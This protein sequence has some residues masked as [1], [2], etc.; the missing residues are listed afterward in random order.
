MGVLDDLGRAIR[1]VEWDRE[2]AM[3]PRAADARGRQLGTL[4]ALH[5]RELVR[6]DVDEAIA[7]LD[8]DGDL[9]PDRRAMV[10]EAQRLRARA[11][12]VPEELVRT[13]AEA[14]A[15]CLASWL[16]ARREDDFA[17]YA[18]R[19]GPL[20]ELKRTEAE[21]VGIGDEPYDGLIDRFEP[22]MLARELE[23]IF[24]ELRVRLPPLVE[25]ARDGDGAALPQR[26]W[27]GSGQMELA[28]ELARALGFDLS[29]GVI[30]TSA[31]PF[32]QSAGRGD[33]RF[34]TRPDPA[35][36]IASILSTMH[37]LGHALYDQGLPE[38]FDGTLLNDASSLGAH[39][40]QS[41]FWENHVGRS[42]AFW[43]FLEPSLRA[44]FPA[45]MKDLDGQRFHAAATRVRPS[46]IR[47]D[48]D[49]VT[50]NLHIVL[51]FELELALIRDDLRVEDLP[52]AWSEGMER[53]VGCRPA[54]DA[55]GVMQDIHWAD[56]ILG[57]FPTYTLGNLYAAQLAES[58]EAELGPIEELVGAG[59][60]GALLGFM[61]TR[62][63]EHGGRYRTRELMRRATGR[64]LDAE[65]FLAHLGRAYGG[66]ARGA[67]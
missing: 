52:G 40:S 34:T 31:H 47:I 16:R 61:R 6:P 51:R 63:H 58:L 24:A 26:D 49:E 11:S 22:G 60:F 64:D 20:I 55:E 15:A 19:L 59:E 4:A 65:A 48:A 12:A 27:P 56:G 23:G 7:S 35:N 10:A 8:A 25:A 18:E 5:H 29:G 53:L 30:D 14:G 46:P 3:P 9:D 37:E 66:G 32:T 33:T 45:Q 28:D 42:Q 67:G 17:A 57:Y 54:N 2:V 1:L 38:R 62:V 43:R 41:R 21:A 13:L 50:Y 44:R 36:P 39:E